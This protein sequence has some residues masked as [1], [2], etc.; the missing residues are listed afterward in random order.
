MHGNAVTCPIANMYGPKLI[1]LG[2]YLF[3]PTLNAL[4]PEL[5]T[6]I[7][8]ERGD[9]MYLSPNWDNLPDDIDTIVCYVNTLDSFNFAALA[10][11]IRGDIH[12]VFYRRLVRIRI[13][14]ERV[15]SLSL[16]AG[17]KTQVG[18]L[19][20]FA[21]LCITMDSNGIELSVEGNSPHDDKEIGQMIRT[22]R[23][24]VVGNW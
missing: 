9:N 17:V 24:S 10:A 23:S 16:I 3:T 11:R 4:V 18:R 20:A 2:A 6:A 8:H 7:F 14:R 1:T 13:E 19:R 22:L 5:S 21:Q 12:H 15:R